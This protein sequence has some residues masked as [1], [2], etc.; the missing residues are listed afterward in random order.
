M[1][2]PTSVKDFGN[3][4]LECRDPFGFWKIKRKSSGVTPEVLSGEYTSQSEAERAITAYEN[5]KSEK[6]EGKIQYKTEDQQRTEARR[7]LTIEKKENAGEE[8]NNA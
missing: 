1:K 4:I 3:Y 7:K 8:E 2:E 5:K 6:A